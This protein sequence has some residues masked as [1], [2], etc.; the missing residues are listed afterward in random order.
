MKVRDQSQVPNSQAF[1]IQ[2]GVAVLEYSCPYLHPLFKG[3][4]VGE[5]SPKVLQNVV[6]M[7][8]ADVYTLL[9]KGPE[10]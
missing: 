4:T 3:V 8:K 10:V 6:I 7:F 1:L 5:G 2:R 9:H